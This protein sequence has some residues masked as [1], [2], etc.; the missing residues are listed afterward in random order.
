MQAGLKHA[1]LQGSA[2]FQGSQSHNWC[3]GLQQQRQGLHL[4][5]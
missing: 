5:Q 4:K 3:Q 2:T 1:T